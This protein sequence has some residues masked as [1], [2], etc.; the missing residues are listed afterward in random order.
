[1]Y[2]QHDLDLIAL[3]MHPDF[4]MSKWMKKAVVAFARGDK[5]FSIPVPPPPAM[6]L[7]ITNCCVHFY[8]NDV[9]D[10]DVIA[11]I[12]DI[13]SGFRNSAI[14][15]I[16]RH[17]MQRVNLEPYF[18]TLD[19]VALTRRA[20]RAVSSLRPGKAPTLAR[21]AAASAQTSLHDLPSDTQHAAAGA[22]VA[23]AAYVKP[24]VTFRPNPAKK[25][26]PAPEENGYVEKTEAY[27]APLPAEDI[28]PKTVP[29]HEVPPAPEPARSDFDNET[30]PAPFGGAPGNVQA[31]DAP[32]DEPEEDAFDLWGSVDKALG[33]H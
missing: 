15:V 22:A 27:T 16:F 25:E 20:D 31:D 7:V 18:N 17:Y 3:Y 32:S 23:K 8:L 26:A 12:R 2:W 10:A 21:P 4:S 6:P 13:R 24:S 19:F 14:R 1:M 30:V 29:V 11:A 33:G 28:R 9:K 5:K